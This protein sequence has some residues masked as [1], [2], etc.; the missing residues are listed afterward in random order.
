MHIGSVGSRN[1]IRDQASQKKSTGASTQND[2]SRDRAFLVSEAL[3][4]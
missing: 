1:L 3:N 4:C 2:N